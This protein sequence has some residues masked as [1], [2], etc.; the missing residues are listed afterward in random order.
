MDVLVCGGKL[1][2]V[3]LSQLSKVNEYIDCLNGGINNIDFDHCVTCHR[4][5]E[6]CEITAKQQVVGSYE[7]LYQQRRMSY[8]FCFLV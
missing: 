8:M 7:P 2:F 4:R 5:T 3:S 6:T 1:T